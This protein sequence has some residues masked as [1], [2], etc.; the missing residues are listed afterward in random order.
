[1]IFF[2]FLDIYAEIHS[3]TVWPP[4]ATASVTECSLIYSLNSLMKT[5]RSA[6]EE[7][8][9]SVFFFSVNEDFQSVVIENVSLCLQDWR[10][11]W[12]DDAFWR[13]LFSTILLVIMF[14]WRPSANNQRYRGCQVVFG[15]FVSFQLQSKA[16]FSV[17]VCQVRLQPSVGWRKWGRGEGAH[18][19]WGL[20]S[21]IFLLH[22]LF[23]LFH[24]FL[25][26][27]F[28]MSLFFIDIASLLVS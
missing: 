7:N 22:S 26:L 10:E 18:D 5:F 25:S 16:G 21:E 15:Q 3:W 11:L 20:R 9:S 13:F 12:I 23:S 8:F 27:F 6:E 17:C 14:L 1:M 2:S 4:P 24:N 19:E 28:L